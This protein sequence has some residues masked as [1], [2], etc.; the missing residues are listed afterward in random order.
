MKYKGKDIVYIEYQEGI[1]HSVATSNETFDF[2]KDYSNECL[3]MHYSSGG[4]VLE[5][6]VPKYREDYKD[7]ACFWLR[8]DI[9]LIGTTNIERIKEPLE[10]DNN[11]NPFENS[12]EVYQ[13]VFC[14][15]CNK[16][17]DEDWCE[18]ITEDKVGNMIYKDDKSFV[19]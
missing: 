1:P 4:G 11:K 10:I 17:L 16:W 18:H 8:N 6:S 2:E 14:K 3:F 7:K 19:D 12:R 9:D 5:F 15:H 13:L